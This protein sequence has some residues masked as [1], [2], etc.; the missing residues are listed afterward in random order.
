[1]QHASHSD[2]AITFSPA[3]LFG[4]PA[5][6]LPRPLFLAI[7]ASND[8]AEGLA[9]SVTARPDG[10]V[11]EGPPAGGHNAPPQGCRPGPCSP[12]ARSRGWRPN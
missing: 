1:M 5:P 6:Q 11:V 8:L 3:A 4:H 9:T 7:V 10:Y 2:H 12:S